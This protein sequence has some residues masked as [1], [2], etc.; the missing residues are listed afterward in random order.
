MGGVFSGRIPLGSFVVNFSKKGI[1]ISKSKEARIESP[2]TYI[3]LGR[4]GFYY[5]RKIGK[6]LHS[7][8]V[9]KLK[10]DDINSFQKSSPDRLLNEIK[11]K[12]ALI[13]YSIVSLIISIIL[14]FIF[15][16]NFP[17]LATSI[18]VGFSML[19][20]YFFFI[21]DIKRK[22]VTVVYQLDEMVNDAFLKMNS[23][24]E[25]LENCERLWI[26]QTKN[27]TNDWKRNA[28]ASSLINKKMFHIQKGLP[29]Y[30]ESN[31]IP[32]WFNVEGK[33]YYFFPDRVLIYKGDLVEVLRYP[34][35]LIASKTIR[36]IESDDVPS[37]SDVIEYTWRYINRDGGPDRRFNNNRQIPIVLYSELDVG[38]YSGINLTFQM[39]DKNAA[40][41]FKILTRKM[42]HLKISPKKVKIPNVMGS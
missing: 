6:G 35:L 28:G 1:S 17:G 8:N 25:V 40:E 29:S 42:I 21:K 11:E 13:R 26:V 5:R 18:L 30:F 15:Y 7:K 36:F 24:F 3:N 38:T 14:L 10:N 37:D 4:G 33:R 16:N 20:Y 39:S 9:L 2:S 12:N 23:G 32:Y 22:T 19:A 31:I 27:A 34:E 41:K